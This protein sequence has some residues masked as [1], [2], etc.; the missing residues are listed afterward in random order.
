M[1]HRLIL[2]IVFLFLLQSCIGLNKKV[3]NVESKKIDN[4]PKQILD[5]SKQE[6]LLYK[7]YILYANLLFDNGKEKNLSKIKHTLERAVFLN[8]GDTQALVGLINIYKRNKNAKEKIMRL[9]KTIISFYEVDLNVAIIVAFACYDYDYIDDA[10][11]LFYK[12]GENKGS[13]D[14]VPFFIVSYIFE[15]NSVADKK[16]YE[17]L[18]FAIENFIKAA[19]ENNSAN[20]ILGSSYY[21]LKDYEKA[22]KYFSKIKPYSK[23]YAI[24]ISDLS[25]IYIARNETDIAILQLKSA[26]QKFP[27][28]ESFYSILIKI[29][30]DIK[31][32][33]NVIKTIDNAFKAG[34]K[35]T[36][37][38]LELAIAYYEKKDKKTA[39]KII[40]NALL[41]Y[42]ND[43][44]VKNF[45]AYFYAEKGAKLE[46]AKKIIN[47]VLNSEIEDG[48]NIGHYLDTLAWIYFKQGKFEEAKKLL[49]KA[50]EETP[51]N[52]KIS[53]HI[54][55]VYYEFSKKN[56]PL[57]KRVALL[58]YEKSLKYIKNNNGDK[59]IIQNKIKTR[60]P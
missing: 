3:A 37:Y 38:Y 1:K 56:K 59:E 55:D 60:F 18:I 58:M 40:D 30:A 19:P 11:K 50:D 16:K 24:A 28:S 31:S 45:V 35:N 10:A 26:I 42:P 22:I 8:T 29:Y 53:E 51:N 25:K 34:I 52:Y 49:L 57:M 9:C 41:K 48:K 21:T 17:K 4:K 32:Y 47:E 13:G 7:S 6:E 12:I 15:K 46:K 33:D 23:N 36:N 44:D 54:G 27:K 39:F 5:I 20:Y 2:I 43:I 14:E